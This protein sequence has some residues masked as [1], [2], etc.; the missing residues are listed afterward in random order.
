MRRI[1]L[2]WLDKMKY[3]G[4]FLAHKPSGISLL[5][6]AGFYFFTLIYLELLLHIIAFDALTG[7][8]AYTAGFS[9]VFAC[10]LALITSLL[11]QKARSFF[12]WLLT[13]L[14]ILLYGSQIVYYFAFGTLYSVAQMQMGGAAVTSFWRETLTTIVKNLPWILAALVPVIA[15]IG[16][17]LFRCRM[18]GPSPAI[19]KVG[20]L[21][22]AVAAQLICVSCVKIGG[23]G[24]FSNYYFYTSNSTTADQAASRFGLLTAFRL[25]IFGAGADSAGDTGYYIPEATTAQT[26]PEQTASVPTQAEEEPDQTAPTQVQTEPPTE[27]TEPEYNVFTIDFDALND[28]TSNKKYEA[29]NNYCA[30]LPGTNKNEYTG[31]LSGYN[32]IL[33]CGE[34]FATAAIHPEVTPTLYKMANEGFVFTNFYNSFPNN[35]IDGEY[36]LCMGLFPDTSRDKAGNS[37]LY[38]RNSYLP[39]CLGNAF[40]EHYGVQSYGYHNN[41]GDYYSRSAS[42]KNLGYKMK[43]KGSGL[44][45]TAKAWPTSDLEMMEQSVDDYIN[46]DIFS[47]YY[48]TF[49]GH[50]SY[51]VNTNGIA[52]K[53]WDTVSH[54]PFSEEARSYLSCNVELDNA[55]K[56]L[57]E[58]LEEAGIADRTAIVIVGDHFPYGLTDAEYSELIGYEIDDFSKYKS[59]AIFWVGGMDEAVIVD[60]YCCNVDILPTILNLWGFNYDSRL[61]AGTDILS[62]SQHVAVRIDKSFYTDKVWFNTNTGEIRYLVD[63]STLPANYVENLVRT[64]E[65]KFSI[66]ADILNER[67]YNFLF[68]DGA[69]HV[70]R[71]SEEATPE[72]TQ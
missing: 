33:V 7:S 10:G 61:L 60:E 1:T 13:C 26:D 22:L 24:Y 17:R 64:I 9:L 11:P 38:S 62:D 2:N 45:F 67:Y 66:S 14:L 37:F 31:M 36:A 58:R 44:T 15:L 39:F 5:A 40:Q 55:M 6:G 52:E 23:T 47:A 29:I 49:S 54:L 34:S 8:F 16:L 19:W 56:Y 42:H 3:K 72:P 53:N 70:I 28:M 41:K 43:F 32:L 27:P 51:N 71:S 68:K 25:N 63:E 69:E 20:L 12:T 4:R 50:M 18:F 46:Q 59:S 35:T 65:T 57:L 21:V 30:S 48:M